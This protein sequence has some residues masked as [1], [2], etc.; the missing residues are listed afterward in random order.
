MHITIY[1]YCNKK[2]NINEENNFIIFF[3]VHTLSNEKKDDCACSTIYYSVKQLNFLRLRDSY[4][5]TA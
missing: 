3:Q 4:H 1:L 5:I 2:Y